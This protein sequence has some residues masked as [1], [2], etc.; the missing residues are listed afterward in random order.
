MDWSKAKT[1]LIIAFIITN[2][3]L[4][5]ALV[6]EK[7][8]TETTVSDEFIDDVIALL[9]NKNIGVA[10]EIPKDKPHLSTMIVGYEKIDIDQL[11]KRFFNDRG[12]V[13]DNGEG[14]KEIINGSKSVVVVN[15]KL[16]SYE[17]KEN[18]GNYPYINE[19]KAIQI[20]MEFL[21]D[22]LFDTSDMKLTYIKEEDGVFYL[23]YS[24]LYGEIIIE[25]AFTNLQVDKR[26]VKR[27]ERLWLNPKDLGDTEIYISTAPKSILGLLN[28]EEIYGK[29]IIDISL[30]Y[31][32]DPQKHEYIGE[33]DEAKQGKVVPAWRIQFSDG[34]KVFIDEY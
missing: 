2:M 9:R 21:K 19:D 23:E 29:T 22:R 24:K 1:I 34:Y 32:F 13:R 25:R 27:F 11:N 28:E 6:G 16:I 10:T 17:D 8:K 12:I 4:I 30:C 31:Y 5:F 7:P 14:L 15:K 26:G 3:L 33:P 20:A 18:H